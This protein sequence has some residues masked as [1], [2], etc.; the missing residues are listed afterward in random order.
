MENNPSADTGMRAYLRL[1][2]Y[3]KP[4]WF[5]F[6]VSI[7]GYLIYAASQPALAH[8]MEYFIDA[9]E[10]KDADLAY[11]VPLAVVCIFVFRGIGSFL[12]NYYIA[13]V[14]L[15]IVHDLRTAMFKQMVQLPRTYYDNNSSGR[16]IAKI[17]YNVTQV[18]AAATDALK[19]VF[20]EGFT[21]IGLLGYMFW[22]QP[23]L[24]LLFLA[25]APIIGVIVKYAGTRFKTISRR[26]Q[27][28]M[29]DITHVANETVS[30]YQVVRSFGGE[31]YEEQ[32]FQRASEKN[33]KQSLKLVKTSAIQTP[34]LQTIIAIAM[35][36]LMYLV[37]KFYS[38]SNPGELVA[39]ITAAG[40]LP[41]PLRQLSGVNATIQKGIAA[42]ESIFELLDSEVEQDGGQYEVERVNGDISIR[43]LS[44]RY[45]G[46]DI[47]VLDD[48]TFDVKQGEMV[49]LVGRSGSGKS[50]LIS[51]LPRFYN[52]QG[53]Q[54]MLDGVDVNDYRLSNLREQ[55]SI[56][57]QNVTLF[58]DTVAANIAYGKLDR[59][60]QADIV[61][62]ADAAYANRFIDELSQGMGTILGEDGVLLS[63]G[64]RQRLAIARAILKNAPI[65]IFDEAT[66]ALDT[67]S[68]RFIQAALEKVMENRTTLVVAHRLST[69]EK[70]DKI[71][72]MDAGR[73]VEMGNHHVLL[74]KGGHY[75]KLYDLQFKEGLAKE[76]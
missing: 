1:L 67:E 30:G 13:K 19:I 5:L 68:E 42:A 28:S 76:D 8:L 49:A 38:D 22:M 25:I 11:L 41:K 7:L 4:Y 27:V 10:G 59:V 2:T 54:L 51:L 58:N 3:V 71:I 72:V 20:R 43:N 50:T 9:L 64:Q 69:I 56:V 70:A 46:S 37:L 26:I 65:L 75:K 31:H 33:V 73:V 21:V 62:A 53:G 47:N 40:L 14:S 61:G 12:G 24:S 55:I 29:G 44:F 18:T 48:I 57:S 35:G 39:Y 34:V 23:T 32:R 52:H 36:V 66:S 63:G 17:T 74:Q 45:P 15:G 60:S 6:V 16:L